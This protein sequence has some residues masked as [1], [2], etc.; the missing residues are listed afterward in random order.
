MPLS[1]TQDD[2]IGEVLRLEKVLRAY[3][4]RF[5]PQSVD[6]DDLLQETYA[7]LFHVPPEQRAGIRNVQAFALTTA[8]NIATDWMRRRRVVSFDSIDDLAAFEAHDPAGLEEIV[9]THQQLVRIARCIADLP[10]RCRDVFTLRRVYGWSQK[11]IARRLNL[12]EGTVE[13]H[14]TRAMRRCAQLMMEPAEEHSQSR[15]KP[16]GWL[17]RWQH[18]IRKRRAREESE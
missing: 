11:E 18:Q 5:A 15:G 8:R 13:Q 9:H 16:A 1:R 3:L 4:H 14:L 2:Y 6:R 17:A 12:T 10:E 7:R